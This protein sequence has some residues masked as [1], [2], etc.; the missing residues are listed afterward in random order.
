MFAAQRADDAEERCRLL[1]KDIQVFYKKKSLFSLLLCDV[2]SSF[3][4]S[5]RVCRWD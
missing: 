3:V 4:F 2:I 5:G 1:E